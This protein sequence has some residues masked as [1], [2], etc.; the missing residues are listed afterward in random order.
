MTLRP[1]PSPPAAP[2]TFKNLEGE[3]LQ[4]PKGTCVEALWIIAGIWI[5][6]V[7]RGLESKLERPQL[8]TPAKTAPDPD[9]REIYRQEYSERLEK[10]DRMI[11]RYRKRAGAVQEAPQEVPQPSGDSERARLRQKAA[12]LG[13]L[14]TGGMPSVIHAEGRESEPADGDG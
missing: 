7:V 11:D 4:K 14:R 3:I 8:Q 12:A 9:D 1:N 10:L 6:Y 5:G 13:L 2:Q